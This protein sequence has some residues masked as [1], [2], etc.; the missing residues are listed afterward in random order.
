ML[1]RIFRTMCGLHCSLTLRDCAFH[2]HQQ[3]FYTNG[4]RLR[5]R[6]RVTTSLPIY[7][8]RGANAEL[9][10][11]EG[12]AV[13]RFR[14][15]HLR[16]QHGPTCNPKVKAALARDSSNASCNT[17]FQVTPYESYIALRRRVERGRA[18]RTAQENDF[19]VHRRGG[20]RER[21]QDRALPYAPFGN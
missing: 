19:S 20:G 2:E 13:H 18:G 11:V 21:D 16:T 10:D 3:R 4:G 12:A 7:A 5:C 17:C 15:R 8:D 6:A 1:K 9:W 14:K